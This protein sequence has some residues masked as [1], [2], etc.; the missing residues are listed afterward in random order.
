[1][2][3]TDHLKSCGVTPRLKPGGKIGLQ[4]VGNLPENDRVEVIAWAKNNRELILKEL[5]GEQKGHKEQKEVES[6]PLKFMPMTTCL[7]GK[8]C[9]HLDAPGERRPVCSKARGA[10]FDL[11]ACPMNKW[12]VKD[13]AP[14]TRLREIVQMFNANDR[15][16]DEYKRLAAEGN[17]LI[18]QVPGEVVAKIFNEEV[19][20]FIADSNN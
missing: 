15:T 3:A 10:V 2:T 11:G 6:A 12:A 19:T 14:E 13:A 8:P 9:P 7:N 1:M 17:K 20:R 16:V 4:G 5:T 18:R